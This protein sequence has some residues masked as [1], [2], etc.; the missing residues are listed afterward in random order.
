MD[1]AAVVEIVKRY[2]DLVRASFP[3]EKVVLYGSYARGCAREESDIDVAVVVDEFEGDI[4]ESSAML[5]RLTDE[6]DVRIEPVI[7]DEKHDRSGFLAEILKT[8]EIIYEKS[9]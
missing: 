9:A 4:L 8:G 2:S 3:A 1:K 7:L 5:Y 6:V